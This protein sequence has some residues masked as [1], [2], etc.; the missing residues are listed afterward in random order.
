[1]ATSPNS[2]TPQTGVID[3]KT[4][5]QSKVTP[6]ATTPI[7][8]PAKDD[9][10]PKFGR[11]QP[12][13]YC[14]VKGKSGPP[15]GNTNNFRHGLRGSTLP[16]SCKYIQHAADHVRRLIENAFDQ[17]LGRAPTFTEANIIKTIYRWYVHE[18]LAARYF[19]KTGDLKYHKEACDAAEKLEKAVTRLN[20]D[21]D[22]K[23]N[24]LDALYSR[25]A[26]THDNG[27]NDGPD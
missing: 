12:S 16:K 1:M 20:L 25:P 10:K 24:V 13:N 9:T 5:A 17:E 6:M 2:S 23:D 21:R 3:P 26:L 27:D 14:G 11:D 15:L 22:T 19:R 18:R 4:R 7:K 8:A